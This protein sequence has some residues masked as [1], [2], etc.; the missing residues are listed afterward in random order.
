[1]TSPGRI[2]FNDLS[3]MPTDLSAAIASAVAGVIESGWFVLGPNHAAFETEFAAYLG[4]REAV[5]VANGTDALE[6]ALAAV[7]VEAGDFVVTVANAGAY[8]S[9]ATRLL[10]GVPVYCDIDPSTLLM[11]AETFEA[12]IAGLPIAPKAVVVTHL[13]GALAPTG[14]IAAVAARHGI[15]VVEDCAQSIGARAG[16][17]MGGLA[18]DIATTSFY[19]TKNLGALG[20]GGAVF[21]DDSSLAEAVRQMRQYGWTA[22]YRIGRAHGRNSRMDELQAAIL[23]VKLPL[24]DAANERRRAIHTV[25]E[26]AAPI[27]AR[28][29]NS[30]SP[31]FTAHLA[32]LTTEHRATAR[33]ALDAAGIGTDVH[34]PIADHR[35]AFPDF[36]PLP[37]ELPVTDWATESVLSIPL[38][39]ELTDDEVARVRDAIDG[40]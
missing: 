29:V 7:G 16:E 38:F 21:T 12:A 4:A 36:T 22:K 5:L 28:L 39:P 27:G 1:M 40:L 2:P 34:Y 8:T 15:R 23:R 6:L 19:P 3:R 18:G 35:Q 25:Y 10:G 31:A 13:Y 24:L 11:S 14:A 17:R 30:S 9:V 37:A 32:V 33:E 20:D 26:S